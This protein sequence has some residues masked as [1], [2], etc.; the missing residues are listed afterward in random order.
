M[1]RTVLFLSA[2]LLSL[3]V[4]GCGQEQNSSGVEENGRAQAVDGT[5]NYEDN[6]E[7][8]E[9]EETASEKTETAL[10]EVPGNFV[11]IE[12]GTFQMG[13][14]ETE[15]WRSGDET[16][17]SVTVSD[18]YMSRY[19]LTQA[20]YEAVMGENPSSF[21]GGDL[22]VENVTWLEAVAY[23]NARSEQE[24]LT[25]AYD[26]EEKSVSWKRSAAGYRLPAEAAW[27]SA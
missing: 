22:P 9:S 26:V 24:G 8:N 4:I 25:P 10:A 21:S 11:H 2:L 18:F 15:A 14:P 3:T 13:S 12:G 1:K 7:G 5:G 19:E 16:Q 27:E 20:E 17:H 23:C 6:T